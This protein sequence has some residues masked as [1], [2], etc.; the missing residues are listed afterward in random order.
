V[1]LSRA[2]ISLSVAF[3]LLLV[4]PQLGRPLIYDEVDFAK[5]ARTVVGPDAE[6]GA[7][8]LRYDRGFIADYPSD[9]DAGQRYQYA[10][11]HPPGYV[12]LLGAW[13]RLFSWGGPVGPGGDFSLRLFG[14]VCGLGTLLLGASLGRR[15]GGPLA[16]ALAALLWATSPFAV[17]SVLLLDVD[18]TVLPLATACFVLLALSPRPTPWGEVAQALAFGAVLWCKLT[19]GPVVAALLLV[20]LVAR[21]RRG[22]AL[23]LGRACLAGVIGALGVWLLLATLAG[24]PPLRPFQDL[25]EALRQVPSAAPLPLIY[26]VGALRALQWLNPLVVGLLVAAP[27]AFRRSSPGAALL[28]SGGVTAILS[29]GKLAAGYPKYLAGPLPLLAAAGGAALAAWTGGKPPARWAGAGLLAGAAGSYILFGPDAL[30]RADDLRLLALWLAAGAALLALAVPLG[31]PRPAG[32]ALGLVVGA[33]LAGSVY[34]AALPASST[35]FYGAGGQV[36]AG[37]WLAGAL[38]EPG[39]V[40][41]DSP[42]R[43]LASRGDSPAAVADREV[44]YYAGGVPF[45]DAERWLDARATGADGVPPLDEVRFVVSRHERVQAL[46]PPEFSPA[47]RFGDYRAWRRTERGSDKARYLLR[48]ST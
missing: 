14:A 39:D 23:R 16:G 29:L 9:P 19:V 24:L 31:A 4:L 5:A 17:Q 25:L 32:L 46:L 41:D 11:W 26:L 44:A 12:L 42:A 2:L 1:S 28:L 35:Y 15:A 36:A 37:R 7:G 20:W 22:E 43:A 30:V 6:A 13:D 27:L 21:G 8:P 40:G 33:G 18:G 3:Y 10:L 38:D 34:Q 47:G 45:V 48:D